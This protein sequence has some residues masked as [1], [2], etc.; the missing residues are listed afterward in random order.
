QQNCCRRG[1]FSIAVAIPSDLYSAHATSTVSL[2]FRER[3]NRSVQESGE[4][5]RYAWGRCGS[6][7]GAYSRR[8][9]P[10]GGDIRFCLAARHRAIARG[11]TSR[12]LKGV[13]M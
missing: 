7:G 9:R 8:A 3:R 5:T 10:F 12:Q 4:V 1:N 13:R 2:E 11:N 6:F